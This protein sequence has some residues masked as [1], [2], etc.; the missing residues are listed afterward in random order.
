MHMFLEMLT[1]NCRRVDTYKEIFFEREDNFV[2]AKYYK[3]QWHKIPILNSYDTVLWVD[4]IVE[5]IQIPTPKNN[6]EPEL[7]TFHHPAFQLS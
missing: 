4:S 3:T 6:V 1:Y 2:K 5:I 7:V